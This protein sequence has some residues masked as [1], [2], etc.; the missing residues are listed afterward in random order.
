[1]PNTREFPGVRRSVVPHVRAG[2]TVV[3]EFIADGI[4]GFAAIIRTLDQLA[5]PAGGLRGVEAVKVG[6]RSLHMVDLPAGKIW[7]ADVPAFALAIGSQ[8]K[9]AF[10][11]THQ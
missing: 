4:P 7:A 11:R 10:A 3:H 2:D 9:G 6:G 5:E 8:D 1:M